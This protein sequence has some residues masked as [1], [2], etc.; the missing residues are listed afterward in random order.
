MDHY[1]PKEHLKPSYAAKESKFA[2]DAEKL[3]DI[4]FHDSQQ[5]R[6][7]KDKYRP[8]LRMT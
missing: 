5:N 8:T 7:T 3:F 4:F 6:E 2:S 1:P